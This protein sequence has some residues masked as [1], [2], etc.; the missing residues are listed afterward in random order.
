MSATGS[1]F[2]CGQ[3]PVSPVIKRLYCMLCIDTEELMEN[4]DDFSKFMK[5][6]NDYALRLNKEEKRFLDSVLRLQ[7]ALTSDASFVI[8]VENVKECHIEV[9]EA[10]NNQIEIVKETMEVQEE[11]LGICFNE[12][13]RVDDRLEFL[14]K[15]VKPLLKRKK[16]LQGE[17]QDN[18]TK[19][20]SRRR[21]LVDLPEKQKELGEDMKPIDASMEKAKRCRKALEEMHHDAVTVAKKLG[22]PVVE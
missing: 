16:A 15:E 18:V 8:V 22:S 17:F 5:E 14:Q 4:F 3:S 1:S 12:E 13:K 9:S 10:V 21:F 20:I 11:I 19:L 6:L 2:E 7:K